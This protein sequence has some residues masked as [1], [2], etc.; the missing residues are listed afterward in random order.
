[1]CAIVGALIWDA[2]RTKRLDACNRLN[3]IFE[4]S[5]ARGPNGYGWLQTY[6]PELGGVRQ[7]QYGSEVYNT[8]YFF[9]ENLVS[10]SV[11]GN[12]RAEPTTEHVQHKTAADQQPYRYNSWAI[13]HN[14]TI[15][16]DA[17]LRTNMLSTTIDSAAIVEQLVRMC[18]SSPTVEQIK[19]CFLNCIRKLQGSYA[20]LAVHKEHPNVI[21]AACNYKPIWYC[22]TTTGVFFASERGFFPERDCPK[23]LP[24]YSAWLFSPDNTR[25][26]GDLYPTS[27]G[28]KRAL[29]V[30]SGGMDS[31]TAAALTQ[32]QGYDVELIHFMYGCKAQSRELQAV[33]N[34]AQALGAPLHLMP[35]PIYDAADSPL[36]NEEAVIA[37]S[38]QGAE[39]AHE[40]VPARN[41]VMLSI[42]TA[43]AEA[44]GFDAIVLGN[45]LEESGAYP[46]NEPEFIA[47]FNDLLPFA[48]ADGKRLQVLMP[49]GHMM[50]PDIVAA[51]VA[52]GA[53]L[54]KTWSCYKGGEL[55]C[56]ECGPCFMRQTAFKIAGIPEV[57][58]YTNKQGN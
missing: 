49:V 20:I 38:E 57:I 55:H 16:N 46:D 54:D 14:G 21:L 2:G 1:M 30:L 11:I 31:T 58:Q 24:P 23:M 29:V 36:L 22:N 48:V 6:L 53:P 56:G 28:P 13:V 26:I 9:P 39:F 42:A 5:V 15:A 35:I 3:V 33:R 17:E 18:P 51:G 19:D 25:R 10:G 47:K 50:K 8:D 7:L 32:A 12:L 45:N 40:W 43:F 41:L 34:I 27:V 44:K 37:T 52:H 4:K